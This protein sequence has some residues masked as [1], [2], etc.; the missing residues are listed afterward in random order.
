MRYPDSDGRRRYRRLRRSRALALGAV[1]IACSLGV[2]VTATV[3]SQRTS[4]APSPASSVARVRIG[5][6]SDRAPSCPDLSHSG[7]LHIKGKR[8]LR[9]DGSGFAYYGITV[10]GG[11]E[12][13]DDN[14]AWEP[15]QG[16][17]MAQ[18][19]AST[20][21]HA[22][23]VR[24]QF[25]EADVFNYG[26]P[27]DGLNTTFLDAACREVRQ[28]RRQH[29]EV[30]IS[31]QT[32]WPDWTEYNPTERTVDFW[33]VM[34]AIYR[35][36][37]GV[38]FD[39]YNEPR[40]QYPRPP[41]SYNGHLPKVNPNWIWRIW[42][43][44][45]N[46]DGEHFIGMQTLYNQVRADRVRNIIWI[47][48]PYY[49]DSLGLAPQHPIHG[50]N[51]VW[52]V[53]HPTLSNKVVWTKFF[54]Y[55]ARRYPMVDGEWGQYASTKPECR[56]GAPTKTAQFLTYLR[57]RNIGLIGW[58]LQPGA[59]LA[60]PHHYTTTNTWVPRDTTDPRHLRI[61]SRMWPNYSCTDRDI[62]EGSGRMMMN[63][64]KRYSHLPTSKR[65][66]R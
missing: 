42:R 7:V 31:D 40:L 27:S 41:S 26:N 34:A 57:S 14:A 49:D 5:N 10:F 24:L 2:S 25:A 64:F 38:S 8:L 35:N 6:E 11:L 12:Q 4:A 37:Q 56:P 62:G 15:A 30:V 32:E 18:I 9:S 28:V 46:F 60:D 47:E 3:A 33:K 44:G 17:A 16:S 36:Q 53:H 51:I 21:W 22:N 65:K 29:Q 63:Y 58:S 45:G 59:M 54:G 23:T 19:K 52:S 50:T 39:L 61:P 43:I 20:W 48:G 1:L 55:L 66:H 13:G